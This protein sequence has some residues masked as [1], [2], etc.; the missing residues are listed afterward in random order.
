M[1]ALRFENGVPG[2]G[3][4]KVHCGECFFKAMW[5]LRWTLHGNRGE[6]R[7]HLCD[8]HMNRLIDNVKQQQPN[9]DKQE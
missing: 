9:A 6:R 2:P 3:V 7:L 5:E 1:Q 8:T 4:S